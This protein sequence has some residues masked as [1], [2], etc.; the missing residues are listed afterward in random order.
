MPRPFVTARVEQRNDFSRL[1]IDPGDIWPLVTVARKTGKTKITCLG[2]TLV[3]LGNDVIHLE[4]E[5]VIGL[6]KLA[7]FATPA[8][9]PPHEVFQRAF[10]TYSVYL[11]RTVVPS[12]LQ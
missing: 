9:P 5:I 10:H 12:A 8:S 3:M 7:V 4:S 11:G 6:G 2:A 1:R